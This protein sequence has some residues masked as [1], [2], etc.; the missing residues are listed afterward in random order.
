MLGLIFIVLGIIMAGYFFG[1]L[2]L[3]SLVIVLPFV[4]FFF[5]TSKICISIKNKRTSN[6]LNTLTSPDCLKLL[7]KEDK[8][9]LAVLIYNYYNNRKEYKK[10]EKKE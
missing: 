10:K 3:Y 2:L 8:K 6:L 9:K 1:K 4:S 5:V 7:K